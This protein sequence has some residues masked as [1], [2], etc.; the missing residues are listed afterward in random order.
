[1]IESIIITFTTEAPKN[2]ETNS[3]RTCSFARW[4][5]EEAIRK[6]KEKLKEQ[7]RQL[8][9]QEAMSDQ[10]KRI[11]ELVG[12]ATEADQVRILHGRL[13]MLFS[14]F[15]VRIVV[16]RALELAG[17]S[18]ETVLLYGRFHGLE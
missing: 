9:F 15:A 5:Q 6:Q 2:Q 14:S 1:M 7:Q 12:K 13:N 18:F 3:E 11:Q 10:E 17:G 8:V 4:R 16:T